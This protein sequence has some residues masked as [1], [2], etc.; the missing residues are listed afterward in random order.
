[1]VTKELEIIPYDAL[2]NIQIGGGFYARLQQLLTSMVATKNKEELAEMIESM[3]ASDDSKPAST[4]HFE[5]LLI[6][7]RSIEEEAKK[8]GVIK[9]ETVEIP[10]DPNQSQ[11]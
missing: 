9:L 11:G 5:T 7:I 8:Q 1:M 2:I 10:T 3:K 4:Y 6:L